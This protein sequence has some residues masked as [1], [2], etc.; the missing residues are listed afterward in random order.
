[1]PLCTLLVTLLLAA[2]P[3]AS[4][5]PSDPLG[6]GPGALPSTVRV[7]PTPNRDA[8]ERAIRERDWDQAE[9][10][11]AAEIEER[12]ES[13]DLLKFLA[14]IFMIDRKP[15][16]AAIAIKKAEQFGELDEATRH[17]LALAYIAM[18]RGDW[19]RPELDRLAASAPEDTTYQYWLA[20]LDYDEGFY[21][22]AIERLEAVITR[23]PGFMRAHDNLGLCYEAQGLP[24]QAIPHFREAIRLNRE[25]A[26]TSPW[27]SLNLGILLRSRGKLD[28]AEQLFRESIR[29]DE[30][31]PQAHYELGALLEQTGRVDEAVEA[32]TRAAALDDS[33]PQPHYALAR[34]YRRQ[35]RMAESREALAAFKRLQDATAE[36]VP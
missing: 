11:L 28:E 8:I 21:A 32:L 16:N 34:I 10:L 33:Y 2:A 5:E 36:K 19:A 27:P 3:G 6:I 20:R 22:S 18:G 4:Q 7:P 29:H 24:D 31:F 9:K 14:G 12:P 13:P 30:R 17:A 1:M 25:A 15:L 35:G 26:V 23:E